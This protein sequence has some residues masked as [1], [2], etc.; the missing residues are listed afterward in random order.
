MT[1]CSRW[2]LIRWDNRISLARSKEEWCRNARHRAEHHWTY[3]LLVL[4]LSLNNKQRTA[5]FQQQALSEISITKKL[6]SSSCWLIIR[7]WAIVSTSFQSTH[8]GLQIINEINT[9]HSIS[10]AGHNNHALTSMHCITTKTN[11]N[12]THSNEQ[13]TNCTVRR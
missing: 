4:I 8:W 11:H 6:K 7:K 3:N 12:H 1:C 5:M 9:V 13:S 2:F 10:Y